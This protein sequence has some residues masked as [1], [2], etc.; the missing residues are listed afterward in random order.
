MS[1]PGT[2]VPADDDDDLGWFSLETTALS[3]SSTHS[4]E[5]MQQRSHKVR[6]AYG[7]RSS[8]NN[9]YMPPRVN[10]VERKE[11]LFGMQGF[12]DGDETLDSSQSSFYAG[13][14]F[15]RTI[16][17]SSS[18]F[19]SSL[20]T[21]SM[22]QT[23]EEPNGIPSTARRNVPPLRPSKQQ[24][25]RS[26]S[27]YTTLPDIPKPHRLKRTSSSSHES[28]GSIQSDS[29]LYRYKENARPEFSEIG[30]LQGL[31]PPSIRQQRKHVRGRRNSMSAAGSPHQ[32]A[33]RKSESASALSHSSYHSMSS[34]PRKANSTQLCRRN[35]I[36]AFPCAYGT[37][38]TPHALATRLNSEH[39][40]Y[41]PTARI[42]HSGGAVDAGLSPSAHSFAASI[43]G[44]SRKRGMSDDPSEGTDDSSFNGAYSV[45]RTSFANN[46]ASRS[47]AAR[48]YSPVS[49]DAYENR[50]VSSCV[51]FDA[52]FNGSNGRVRKGGGVMDI[53]SSDDD[54]SLAKSMSDES[55]DSDAETSPIDVNSDK[56]GAPVL[57]VRTDEDVLASM[58]SEEA[59]EFLIKELRDFKLKTGRNKKSSFGTFQSHLTGKWSQDHR[60]RYISWAG[61][62]L[63]FCVKNVGP[64]RTYLEMKKAQALSKLELLESAWRLHRT[65][66][67]GKKASLA[68]DGMENERKP[69]LLDTV[70]NLG[71]SLGSPTL[72]PVHGISIRLP[73]ANDTESLLDH[74]QTLSLRE[75]NPTLTLARLVTLDKHPSS[76]PSAF[77]PDNPR[78]KCRLSL[79]SHAST[80]GDFMRL[81]R[82]GQSPA[83]IERRSKRQQKLS[84]CA[85]SLKPNHRQ[86]E[87]TPMNNGTAPAGHQ[88]SFDFV[89][90][91]LMKQACQAWGS[92]PVEG[93]DWGCSERCDE[94]HLAMLSSKFLAWLAEAGQLG[95][96]ESTLG[97]IFPVDRSANVCLDLDD[98][99]GCSD[100]EDGYEDTDSDSLPAMITKEMAMASINVHENVADEASMRE[101]RRLSTSLAKYKRMSL[102]ASAN[103]SAMH[104]RKSLCLSLSKISSEV[105]H[106]DLPTSMNSFTSPLAG[107]KSIEKQHPI[108][109][110]MDAPHILH[111]IFGFLEGAELLTT[112]PLVCS[113]WS[114]AATEAYANL[115]LAS[116]RC[117]SPGIDRH[118]FEGEGVDDRNSV[119]ESMERSWSY[120]MKTFPHASFLGQGGLKRVYKVKNAAVN[121]PEAVSV[122]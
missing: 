18:S 103:P 20:G 110:I 21:S 1:S 76:R 98:V 115:L 105:F 62:R 111:H 101:E 33:M 57:M 119:A 61:K 59:L 118:L 3:T 85:N 89:T 71:T 12:D 77:K 117:P 37:D 70:S 122:M 11:R 81:Y 88:P 46:S 92:R 95:S 23:T 73:E 22:S 35:S 75:S 48:R 68:A 45:P 19:P 58:P 34:Y 94:R 79:D 84:L 42:L 25:R 60:N 30:E 65:R 109:K 97:E 14:G 102:C 69:I 54:V 41:S 24:H 38:V 4:P 10:T 6:R 28:K 15:E 114:D 108:I 72:P 43:G 113:A 90:T 36:S 51:P 106:R 53:N 17:D 26:V 66:E 78:E 74:F 67:Q 64:G 99:E 91:P 29:F 49:D 52:Q 50:P 47:C 40:A 116:V 104:R 16:S 13:L 39:S 93:M 121:V 80:E 120:L 107:Q 112:V 63:G 8:R 87:G 83:P 44:S 86:L 27:S 9:D 7:T 55:D 2:M 100:D 31:G 82:H 5:R 96:S 32:V 56:L